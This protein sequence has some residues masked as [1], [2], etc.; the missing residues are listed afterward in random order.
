MLEALKTIVG[1]LE[2]NNLNSTAKT[3]QDELSNVDD[4]V[5]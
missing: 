2:A 3:L 5:I 4:Y 1:F